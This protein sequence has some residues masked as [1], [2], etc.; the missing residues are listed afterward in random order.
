MPVIPDLLHPEPRLWVKEAELRQVLTFA[1]AS[2]SGSDSF[3]RALEQ[4]G[5]APSR[6]APDCFAKDLFI[7]DLVARCFQFSLGARRIKPRRRSLVPLITNPPDDE[8]TVKF[9]HGILAELVDKPALKASLERAWAAVEDVFAALEGPERG[10][11]HARLERRLEILRAAATAFDVLASSFEGARSGLSLL[12]QFGSEV[13]AS[14]GYKNLTELLD[15]EGHLATVNVR[16]RLSRDGRLRGFEIVRVEENKSNRYYVSPFGRWFGRLKRFIRGY[17]F[18]EDEVLG[19]LVQSVYDGIEPALLLLFQLRRDLEFYLAALGFRAFAEQKGLAVCLPTMRP[20]E[21]DT[22]LPP[23]RFVALYNPHLLLEENAPR[24]S[25]LVIGGSAL[26]L[27]TGPNSGGKTRLLQAV[28]LAQLLAQVGFFVPAKSAELVRRN[29][30]FVSVVEEATA[31][32]R[33]GRLGTELLRI[34]RLFEKLDWGSLVI[35][36]ELCSGTNPSE[37]EEIFRLVV[38]LLTEIEPQ[39]VVTTHFLHFAATLEAE[40]PV[41][42]LEFMQV[43]LDD[44]QTPTFGFVPGV[45]TTSLARRTAERLGVTKEALRELVDR[46]KRARSRAG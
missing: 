31:D 24:P 27:V 18:R 1:F 12:G 2:G 25:D 15:H 26:L 38:D 33:E 14:D 46:S 16:L 39:T 42:R 30:L 40:R 8:R 4:T 28:G 44:T 3:E 23:S 7:E 35:V 22:V 10:R 11:H 20:A 36:D 37:A 17:L 9:R 6:F 34:R 29:G 5:A 32:A 21:P 43:E 41:P 13:R 45:A 19:R